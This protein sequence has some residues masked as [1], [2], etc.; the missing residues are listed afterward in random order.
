MLSP[1]IFSIVPEAVDIVPGLVRFSRGLGQLLSAEA[2][3][4]GW[5]EASLELRLTPNRGSVGAPGCAQPRSEGT[6]PR[7]R[8]G[9]HAAGYRSRGHQFGRENGLPRRHPSQERA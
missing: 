8:A 6:T 5:P 2:S 4:A 1:F 3:R 9:V 7:D